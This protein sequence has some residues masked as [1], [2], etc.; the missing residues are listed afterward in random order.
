MKIFI[1]EQDPY[2]AKLIQDLLSIY[3]Y[4]LVTINHIS[5]LFR[6]AHFQR[7]KIIVVDET[8]VEQAPQDFFRRLRRDP[9]TAKIPVIFIKN[10]SSNINQMEI[11]NLTEIV[12]EP[13]KIK[14]FRHFI[15][16]WTIFRSLY[17]QN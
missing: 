1:C 8:F 10:K 6:K 4:R 2:R 7:P 16:R 9:I 11:D 3:N 17:L 12:S 14:N 5:D 13:F 15:D